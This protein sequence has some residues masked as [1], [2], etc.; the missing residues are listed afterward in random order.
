[1][2]HSGS[3]NRIYLLVRRRALST[4]EEIV[5]GVQEAGS[6]GMSFHRPELVLVLRKLK[7]LGKTKGRDGGCGERW[8]RRVRR[9]RGNVSKY[10]PLGNQRRSGLGLSRSFH[11][12]EPEAVQSRPLST[13]DRNLVQEQDITHIAFANANTLHHLITYIIPEYPTRHLCP[14]L[15][16]PHNQLS[17]MPNKKQR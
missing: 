6:M 1:V 11:P 3:L 12:P 14:L 16:L 4:A 8:I 9:I 15:Y 5:E 17:R 13:T 10:C 2:N 7:E